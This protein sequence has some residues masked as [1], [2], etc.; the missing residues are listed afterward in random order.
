[1]KKTDIAN[2]QDQLPKPKNWTP[3]INPYKVTQH[4][5]GV[6][7]WIYE[8]NMYK[9][10]AI[11]FTVWSVLLMSLAIVFI[12]ISVML[13]IE[14]E[15]ILQF[16][17][18]DSKYGVLALFIFFLT[19]IPA[20]LI[21]AKQYGGKYIVIFEMDEEKIVH[22][23]MKSQFKKAQALSAFTILAGMASG[24]LSM[25]GL[26]IV[27]ATRDSITS[28]Y[29]AVRQIKSRKIMN[30]IK[31]NNLFQ[32]NQIY[33]SKAD[34]DFVFKYLQEHVRKAKKEKDLQKAEEKKKKK[35]EKR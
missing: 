12:F 19:S 3:E 13:L 16:S 21:V 27:N 26:G 28:Y 15:S 22:K 35:E 6:Y 23:Q 33:V 14:G 32:H 5:D 9:N 7:R 4:P 20:Y 25:T 11:L 31:V 17:W 24:N 8:F 2:I 30:L 1:M 10:P 18:D 29:S 34:Y